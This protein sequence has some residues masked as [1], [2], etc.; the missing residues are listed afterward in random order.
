MA[1]GLKIKLEDCNMKYFG[2]AAAALMMT[3]GAS[4]GTITEVCS[5]ATSAPGSAVITPTTLNCGLFAALTGG[6]TAVSLQIEAADSYNNGVLGQTNTFEFD[7]SSILAAIDGPVGPTPNTCVVTSNNSASLGS[8][9]DQ[10][11]GSGLTGNS[12]A[13]PYNF[14]NAITANLGNYFGVGT[15]NVAAVTSALDGGGLLSSGTVADQLFAVLTYAPPQTGT[16]EP[17]SM[18]LLGSGLL[19]AGLLGRKKFAARK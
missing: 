11:S 4:A 7:Y 10:I 14:G 15:F 5:G 3:I 12:G 9:V 13:N 19:A 8:C 6:N 18:M 17:G 1:R 16:P 2:L